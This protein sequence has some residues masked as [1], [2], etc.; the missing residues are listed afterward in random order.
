MAELFTHIVAG[1][2]IGVVL[3]WRYE[4]I[5]YPFVTFVMVGAA[6]PDLNRIGLVVP[7]DTVATILGV[8][9]SWS[10]LHR[11]GGTLVII[12]IGALL[13]PKEYRRAVFAL[14]FIGAASHYALDF[15]LYKPSG[16]T[17]TLLWPFITHGFEVEGFY[18]SSDRWP[19][20]VATAAAAVVWAVD[21]R[22]MRTTETA[23]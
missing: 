12:C 2:I 8:P 6:L 17:S 5:T 21:Q 13:V 4:W 22:H 18:L 7:A 10:P 9:F 1:Y 3:S 15:F 14:L 11:A 23:T 19:A 16:V 20:V